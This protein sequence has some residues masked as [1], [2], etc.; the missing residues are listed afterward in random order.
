M[1]ASKY[2]FMAGKIPRK[3]HF[4]ESLFAPFIVDCILG[5]RDVVPY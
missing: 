5:A 4:A 2:L 1:D 3:S